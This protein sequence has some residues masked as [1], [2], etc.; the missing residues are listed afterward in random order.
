[1]LLEERSMLESKPKLTQGHEVGSMNKPLDV[2]L[3]DIHSESVERHRMLE[4]LCWAHGCQC[5]STSPLYILAGLLVV[6]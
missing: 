4:S 1:M 6:Y 2:A 5:C 3:K